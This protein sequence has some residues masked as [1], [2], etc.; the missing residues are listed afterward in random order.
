MSSV[1]KILGVR[2]TRY[3]V[4]FRTPKG[5]SRSKTF[6]RK[7]DAE[8]FAAT[9]DVDKSIGRFADPKLG[10]VSFREFAESWFEVKRASVG[11][12]TLQNLRARLDRHILP[13]LGGTRMADV[14]PHE[15]RAWVAELSSSKGLAPATVKATFGVLRQIMATAE[16]DGVVA[17]TPCVGITLPRD[18]GRQPMTFLTATQV[19]ALAAAV[20]DRYRVLILTAAYT[21]LRA[22]ELG[23]LRL[24]HVNVLHRRLHVIESI[25]EVNGVQFT[26]PTKSGVPRVV[27]L[28]DFLARE[29]EQHIARY[30]SAGGYVFTARDGGPIRHRNFMARHFKPAVIRAGLPTTLRFHDLRHTA[31]SLLISLGAN[32]K[33]IQERLGHSTIQLTFDRYGHLFEGHDDQLRDGLDDLYASSAVSRLCHDDEK[34]EPEQAHPARKMPVTRPFVGADDGIRT[35]DPNL[36]KVVLYQLSHVRVGVTG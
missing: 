33:Q 32:P 6:D 29:L 21:G 1:T 19:Q 34:P 7:A 9:T 17:R 8:R 26:G 5:A 13:R 31:A 3:R 15:V 12:G 16:I 4:R 25:G 22:G 18:V 30:P 14:R 36:G 23:A 27:S 28:P 10:R 20:D 35:R 11:P 24:E 2:G